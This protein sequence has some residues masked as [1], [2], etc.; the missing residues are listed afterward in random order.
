ME[1]HVCMYS[2]HTIVKKIGCHFPGGILQLREVVSF[3]TGLHLQFLYG[4]NN[5]HVVAVFSS[6]K[7]GNAAEEQLSIDKVLSWESLHQL[8]ANT[9]H[10][11]FGR[12]SHASACEVMTYEEFRA[13]QEEGGQYDEIHDRWHQ[14]AKQTSERIEAENDMVFGR[15]FRVRL[16]LQLDKKEAWIEQEM[17]PL[18]QLQEEDF[19]IY[20]LHRDFSIAVRQFRH[21]WLRTCLFLLLEVGIVLRRVELIL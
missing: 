12:N 1:S 6:A 21:E 13:H 3:T 10:L 11:Q 4:E 15:S 17:I 5:D 7:E 8:W 18:Q 16:Y 20:F 2:K 19:G 14:E 9:L